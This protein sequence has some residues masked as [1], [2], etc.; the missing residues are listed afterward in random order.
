[1]KVLTQEQLADYDRH[2]YMGG[3]KGGAKGLA[4]SLPAAWYAHN[5]YAYYRSLPLQIKALSVMMVTVPWAVVDAEL[6]SRVFEEEQWKKRAGYHDTHALEELMRQQ[7]RGGNRNQTLDWIEGHKWSLVGL[8]WVT[9]ISA[10][11]GIIMR[12]PLQTTAQKAVQA[13]MWAQGLTVGMLMAAG[14]LT[15]LRGSDS[16]EAERN[17]NTHSWRMQVPELAKEDAIAAYKKSQESVTTSS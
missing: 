10:A 3:L 1:M 11:F 2:V 8:G 12:D 6:T 15:Q 16:I 4:L 17:V 7:R 13:R 5:K 14:A 9:S